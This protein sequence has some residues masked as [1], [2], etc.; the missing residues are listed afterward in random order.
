MTARY[1]EAGALESMGRRDDARDALEE[2]LRL[3]P[4][5]AVTLAVIGDLEM[6]AGEPRRRPRRYREALERNPGDVGLRELVEAT[7]P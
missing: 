7:A 1:L 6:R 5:N 2:A 3:E 4:A